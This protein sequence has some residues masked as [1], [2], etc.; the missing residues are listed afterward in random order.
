[1]PKAKVKHT[2][3]SVPP[4]I[5]IC[6]CGHLGGAADT[7]HAPRYALGHGPCTVA[8]CRCTQFSWDGWATEQEI[9]DYRSENIHHA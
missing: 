6:D 1:M 9:A 4:K 7:Q 5:G 3:T 8:D 2:R